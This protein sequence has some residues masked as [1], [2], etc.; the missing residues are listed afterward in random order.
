MNVS[1]TQS[2]NNTKTSSKKQKK[3]YVGYDELSI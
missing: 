2:N 1:N 3:S